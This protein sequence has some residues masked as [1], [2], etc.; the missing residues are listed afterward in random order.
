MTL[1]VTIGKVIV[2]RDEENG[3]AFVWI[4]QCPDADFDVSALS[5]MIN[6]REAYRS[7]SSSFWRFWRK[8]DVLGVV[9]EE[10]RNNS[11][12]NDMDVIFL[13]KYVERIN[14]VQENSFDTEVDKDRLRWLKYWVNK[15]VE[16]YGKDAGISFG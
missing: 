10:M 3:H 7:G 15:A 14:Q 11:D 6:P 9:Y 13:E 16:L 5:F 12:T 1:D 8:N 4:E 2:E